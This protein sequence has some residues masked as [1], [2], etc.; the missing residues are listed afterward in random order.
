VIL[1]VVA[2]KLP[3]DPDWHEHKWFATALG[4]RCV[5]CGVFEKDLAEARE[6]YRLAMAEATSA[7]DVEPEPVA[8]VEEPVVLLAGK[9]HR[10]PRRPRR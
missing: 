7:G 10:G 3:H 1:F 9:S 4:G 5:G 2:W 6:R 8:E